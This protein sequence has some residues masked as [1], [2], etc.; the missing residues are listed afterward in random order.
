M[1]CGEGGGERGEGHVC[2]VCWGG[3]EPRVTHPSLHTHGATDG[4]ASD[5][6]AKASKRM[7]SRRAAPMTWKQSG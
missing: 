6:H 4:C 7:G 2:H 3:G 1:R 5:D